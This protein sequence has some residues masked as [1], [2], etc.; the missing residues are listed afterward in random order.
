MAKLSEAE[1]RFIVQALACYDTPTQVAEAVKEEFGTVLDRGH[2]GCYDPTKV[3]GKDL[4]KKWRDLFAATREAFKNELTEIPIAQ[5]SY[6]LKVL[7]RIVS[8][9]ESMKNMPLALQVLEQ[10]AKECGDMYVNRKPQEG[11]G[12][13]GEAPQPVRVIVQVQDASADADG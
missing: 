8:K 9:A 10:A 1:K 13:G 4:A 11:D 12:K 3:S 5:R 2:V 6:R 7:Q